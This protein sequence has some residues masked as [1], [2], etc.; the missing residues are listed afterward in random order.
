MFCEV[1]EC[2]IQDSFLGELCS[3]EKV[4]SFGH[5]A[6]V[7]LYITFYFAVPLNMIVMVLFLSY[8]KPYR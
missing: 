2:L 6:D 5:E 4:N 8:S 7:I 3:I 1:L